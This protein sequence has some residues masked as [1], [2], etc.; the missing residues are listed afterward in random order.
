MYWHIA[1]PKYRGVKCL[2]ERDGKFLLVKLAYGHKGWTLPGGKV[3]RGESFEEGALRELKEETNARPAKLD[4]LAEYQSTREGKR[5]TVQCFYGTTD[6]GVTKIDPLEI[7]E[8][9]WFARADFPSNRSDRIDQI[10]GFYDSRQ[11]I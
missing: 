8:A 11:N 10:M 2:I 1:K 3:E 4:F 9:G 5:D 6:S 7:A